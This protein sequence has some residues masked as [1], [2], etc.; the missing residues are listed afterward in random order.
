MGREGRG[1]MGREG[2]GGEGKLRAGSSQGEGLRFRDGEKGRPPKELLRRP[3]YLRLR[4]GDG[5]RI[6]TLV[7]VGRLRVQ[8][9]GRLYQWLLSGQKWFGVKDGVSIG[10]LRRVE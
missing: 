10:A 4:K 1:G 3:G 7:R 9:E 2:R 6:R 8:G 5:V